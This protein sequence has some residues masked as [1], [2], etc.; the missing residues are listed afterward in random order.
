MIQIIANIGAFIFG[1]M[2]SWS[3]AVAEQMIENKDYDVWVTSEMFGWL[4]GIFAIGGTVSTLISGYTRSVLGTKWT[5][6]VVNIPIVIGH[7][8]I[9]YANNFSMVKCITQN[10]KI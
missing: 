10:F 6:I 1:L 9:I 2:L 7:L 3:A 8:L 5:I 4:P